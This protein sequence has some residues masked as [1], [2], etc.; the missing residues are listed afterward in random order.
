[1]NVRTAL[2]L[3]MLAAMTLAAVSACAPMQQ[4]AG[5]T[6]P[7]DDAALVARVREALNSGGLDASQIDVST[8]RGVVLL[9]G[10]ARD[11]QTIERAEVIVRRVPGVADVRNDIRLIAGGPER[12]R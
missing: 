10:F 12:R 1:M 4:P 9:T 7:P 11:Q 3:A 6:V 8:S 5:P 2:A